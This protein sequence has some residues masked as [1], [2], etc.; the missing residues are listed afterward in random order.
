MSAT[1]GN[2]AVRLCT[3][4]GNQEDERTTFR[5]IL[6]ET[7]GEVAVQL[8][9]NS[10]LTVASIAAFLRYDDPTAF[11]RAFKSW[12]GVGPAKWRRDRQ[13]AKP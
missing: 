5:Q 13:K 1:C 12:S 3:W 2:D 11:S 10:E 9:E 6:V 4:L 8:L 7:R